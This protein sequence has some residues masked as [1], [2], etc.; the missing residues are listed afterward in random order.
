MSQYQTEQKEYTYTIVG[1]YESNPSQKTISICPPSDG[2]LSAEKKAD[3]V[4]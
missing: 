2:L 4:K 3:T 1:G